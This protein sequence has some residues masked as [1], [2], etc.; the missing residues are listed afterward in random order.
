M[1]ALK[2]YEG[3]VEITAFE[4]YHSLIFGGVLPTDIKTVLLYK[5]NAL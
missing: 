4:M 3:V 5:L 2:F 1:E